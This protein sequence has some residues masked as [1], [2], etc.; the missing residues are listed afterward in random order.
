MKLILDGWEVADEFVRRP[1]TNFAMSYITCTFDGLRN[2]CGALH[3]QDANTTS[4]SLN[5]WDFPQMIT[6][7]STEIHS[8]AGDTV[9]RSKIDIALVGRSHTS[10]RPKYHPLLTLRR[11]G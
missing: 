4:I 10:N 2:L 3:V 6:G 5:G 7:S 1:I 9:V 11:L 8:C